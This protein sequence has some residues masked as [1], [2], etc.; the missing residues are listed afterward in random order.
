MRALATAE[1]RLGALCG[2]SKPY[3][4]C[5]AAYER[6]RE[7]A[8]ANDT[9]GVTLHK[10]GDLAGSLREL[11]RSASLYQALIKPGSDREAER[12]PAE[13]RVDIAETLID[14][15]GPASLTRAAAEY[16]EAHRLNAALR[17]RGGL[18]KSYY[19]HLDELAGLAAKVRRAA[20]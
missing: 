14:I 7:I 10:A 17:G 19:P 8:A 18:P 20:R 1:K 9:L 2:V 5:R 13:V 4:E 16:R 12:D 15:G 3:A 6:A 11:E